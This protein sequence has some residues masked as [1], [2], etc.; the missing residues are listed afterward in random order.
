M[1]QYT[2]GSL[3]SLP[4]GY[5]KKD[6]EN[7]QEVEGEEERDGVEG[8]AFMFELTRSLLQYPNRLLPSILVRTKE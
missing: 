1:I 7:E 5:T 3:G 6:G 8:C 4:L 2:S